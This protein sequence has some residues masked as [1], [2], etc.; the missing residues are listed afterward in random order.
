MKEYRKNN[1]E[2]IAKL[3]K[4]RYDIWLKRNKENNREFLKEYQKEWRK[5]NIERKR[6]LNAKWKKN[7][8]RKDLQFNLNS[9]MN[10]ALNHSLKGNKAGRHW[11]TLV[12]YALGDLIKRLK[13]TMP[14][15]YTWQ[16]Y[17]EGR[18]HVDHKIP[19]SAFNF[20]KPENPD[21]KKCWALKNL[22][23]LPARENLIKGS[24]LSKPFQPALK[25]SLISKPTPITV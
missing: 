23:L 6:E 20:N 19:V 4:I 21:F 24:K 14:G 8:N 12:G 10:R 5:N 18:L 3:S 17:L 13:K 7:K 2:R 9:R 11:E 15:G 25:I 16:D 1:K 22:Q